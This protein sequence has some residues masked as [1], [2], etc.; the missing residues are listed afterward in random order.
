MN[1]RRVE[2][3][4]ELYHYGELAKDKVIQIKKHIQ[5][6]PNCRKEAQRVGEVLSLVSEKG[7]LKLSLSYKRSL[8]KRILTALSLEKEAPERFLLRWPVWASAAVSIA[9]LVFF[10]NFWHLFS[11]KNIL[12]WEQAN[13]S[14]ELDSVEGIILLL[15]EKDTGREV[16]SLEERIAT[17]EK[18]VTL[19]SFTKKETSAGSWDEKLENLWIEIEDLEQEIEIFP[20]QTRIFKGSNLVS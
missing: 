20:L 10:M 11:A 13:L 12:D 16:I 18:E 14:S 19:V 7:K 15:Q 17:L 9:L 2:D 8:L 4:L 5:Q 6:C 3:L 1:C